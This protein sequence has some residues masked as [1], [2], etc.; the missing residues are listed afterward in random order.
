MN[1][2]ELSFPSEQELFRLFGSGSVNQFERAYTLEEI[3]EL[4][5]AIERV[6]RLRVQA[7]KIAQE[8]WSMEDS[9]KK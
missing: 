1:N 2:I 4:T 5:T 7:E 3:K 8:L 9:A 6:K